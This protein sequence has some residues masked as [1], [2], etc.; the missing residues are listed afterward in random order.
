MKNIIF[1]LLFV[2]GILVI[3]SCKKS[4]NPA[5]ELEVVSIPCRVTESLDLVNGHKT[6]FKYDKQGRVIEQ[7]IIFAK[8]INTTTLMYVAYFDKLAVSYNP[9]S[10]IVTRYYLN[11]RGSADSIIM[12]VFILQPFRRVKESY[13]SYHQYNEHNELLKEVTYYSDYLNQTAQYE[14]SF[15]WKNG[16]PVKKIK[17]NSEGETTTEVMNYSSEPNKILLPDFIEDYF[18]GKKPNNLVKEIETVDGKAIGSFLY[19]LDKDGHVVEQYF[20]TETGYVYDRSF[21]WTCSF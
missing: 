21:S 14:E 2:S 20:S 9:D 6:Q 15:A 12:Q 19:Q 3:G 16:N 1:K 10:S 7:K 8:P 5:Q 11:S 13:A 18:L 4:E 17:I